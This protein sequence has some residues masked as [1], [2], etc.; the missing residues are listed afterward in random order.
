MIVL[1]NIE[2]EV[3]AT[4]IV[5]DAHVDVGFDVAHS[6]SFNDD[7]DIDV[8]IAAAAVNVDDLINCHVDAV[9]DVED[10]V[11]VTIVVLLF[12]KMMMALEF[13]LFVD[14]NDRGDTTYICRKYFG[15]FCWCSLMMVLILT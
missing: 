4:I 2:P 3:A 6:V 7:V 12:L 15:C 8:D 10:D 1:I 13:A 5:D 9:V 11:I 14:V